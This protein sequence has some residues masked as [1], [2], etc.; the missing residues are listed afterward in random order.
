MSKLFRIWGP[1]QASL[2]MTEPEP[3]FFSDLVISL[4]SL[5]N[6]AHLVFNLN[7]FGSDMQVSSNSVQLT[8][9]LNGPKCEKGRIIYYEFL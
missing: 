9:L 5:K 4:D 7:N 1:I 8:V 2:Y 6:S 3:K